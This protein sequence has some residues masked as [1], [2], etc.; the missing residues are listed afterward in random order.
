MKPLIPHLVRVAVIS[1]IAIPAL[2]RAG[3]ARIVSGADSSAGGPHVKAFTG[4]TQTNGAS[5]FAYAPTFSGGVRVAAGD[6]NGDGA[7][8]IIT[9]SG[10]G[11][12][13][14]KAFSGRDLSE[15]H[16]FLP[17]DAGFAGGVFVAA[18]DVNGDGF[19]DVVTGTGAGTQGHV[20]VFDGRTGQLL[21][22]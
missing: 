17:Y 7:P 3:V 15:L 19:D 13:Q 2:A 22:S 16:N 11:S 1:L 18:G 21:V 14:G 10:P 20:K 8:D 4:R 9:G 5:F 12:A 6:L